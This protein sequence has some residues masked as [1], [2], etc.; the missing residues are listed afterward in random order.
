SGAGLRRAHC[1]IFRLF[2]CLRL[3]RSFRRPPHRHSRAV[4]NAVSRH[5][6]HPRDFVLACAAQGIGFSDCAHHRHG[7]LA[8]HRLVFLLFG[9]CP[10]PPPPAP[11]HASSCPH[12]PPPP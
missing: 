6:A 4:R 10:F 3:H 8:V 5:C 7:V 1:R 11:R 9:F 12:V 2:A